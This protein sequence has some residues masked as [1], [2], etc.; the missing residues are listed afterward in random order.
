[1]KKKR[2]KDRELQKMELEMKERES[3]RRCE[4]EMMCLRQSGHSF[5]YGFPSNQS[6]A[7]YDNPVDGNVYEN[8]Q[9]QPQPYFSDRGRSYFD[10]S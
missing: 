9:D 7:G 4:L 3:R 10:L 6:L 1:M 8:K 2:E 5:H